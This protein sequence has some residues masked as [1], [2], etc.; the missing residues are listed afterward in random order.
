M[1]RFIKLTVINNNIIYEV[2]IMSYITGKIRSSRRAI[3]F[4]VVDHVD[5]ETEDKILEAFGIDSN[6]YDI[7]S[8]KSERGDDTIYGQ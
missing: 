8:S 5:S 3:P 6:T 1:Q 4:C 7:P 2:N